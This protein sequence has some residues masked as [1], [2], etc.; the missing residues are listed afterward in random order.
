MTQLAG[1]LLRRL[2]VW[3][4]VVFLHQNVSAKVCT[5]RRMCFFRL[6]DLEVGPGI[7]Q[8]PSSPLYIKAQRVL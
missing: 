1:A 8:R 2:Q 6:K 4:I 3:E 7:E 5:Y